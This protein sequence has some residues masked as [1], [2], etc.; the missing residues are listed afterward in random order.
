MKQPSDELIQEV[1]NEIVRVSQDL[2]HYAEEY[3]E[4]AYDA[5]N[6]QIYIDEMI[7]GIADR[8]QQAAE[9][10]IRKVRIEERKLRKATSE[11]KKTLTH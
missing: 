4:G 8:A 9:H 1:A 3:A 11:E 6:K 7:K 10:I 2:Q 5:K